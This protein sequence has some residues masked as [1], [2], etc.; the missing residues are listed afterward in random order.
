VVPRSEVARL[1]QSR[2]QRSVGTAF[3]RGAGRGAL[4][5][6]GVSA[7]LLGVAAL[8]EARDPCSD[9]FVNAP[10]AAA[11][12]GVPFTA[13]TTVVGG[14]VGLRFRERWTPLP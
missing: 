13:L 3:W 9:C 11:I 1:E 8:S 14:V 4:V 10:L 7:A 2:G 5:G 12:V 6:V